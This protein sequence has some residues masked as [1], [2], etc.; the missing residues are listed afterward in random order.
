M[1]REVLEEQGYVL[2]K[3]FLPRARALEAQAEIQGRQKDLAANLEGSANSLFEPSAYGLE[4]G[5]IKYL[6]HPQVFFQSLAQILSAELFELAANS[7][8]G[9]VFC[10]GIELHQKFPGISCTP[11]HQDNFYF[12]LDIERNRAITMYFA[13]NDQSADMGALGFY[14]RTHKSQF[15]HHASSTVGFSSGISRCDLEEYEYLCPEMGAGDLII[16]HCNIVHEAAAN[17][18]QGVRSNIAV[19]MFPAN[20]IYDAN[21]QKQYEEFKGTSVRSL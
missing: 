12:G 7:C 13:L 19:R 4:N 3:G 10:S 17:G 1:S 9:K 14:P 5:T 11:P 21:L 20:P 2:I 16:H 6:K 15:S 18:T 8:D